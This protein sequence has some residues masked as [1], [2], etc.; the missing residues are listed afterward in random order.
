MHIKDIGFLKKYAA[1]VLVFVVIASRRR[2]NPG[3]VFLAH[4]ATAS[5]AGSNTGEL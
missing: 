3:G 5:V 4:I 1:E 2:S